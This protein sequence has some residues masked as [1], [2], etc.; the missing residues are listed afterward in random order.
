MAKKKNLYDTLRANLVSVLP[1]GVPENSLICPLCW[2]TVTF[3]ELTIEHCVPQSV[4]GRRETLTC[5]KC[6][7][8]SGRTVD[9]HLARHQRLV[10]AANGE[11]AMKSRLVFTEE[12]SMTTNLQIERDGSRTLSIVGKAS[13]PESV[14][15]LLAMAQ[16]GK[17]PKD[18]FKVTI[19]D[20]PNEVRVKFA[21]LR[22][23]YLSAFHQLGY[24]FAFSESGEFLRNIFSATVPD[25]RTLR[26]LTGVKADVRK[27]PD[28]ARSFIII[29]FEIEG[30][31]P[32]SEGG[33]STSKCLIGL[34]VFLKLTI[35][36]SSIH[37]IMI[38]AG[39]SSPREFLAL[40]QL[41]AEEKPEKMTFT[42]KAG[43]IG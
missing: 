6:N 19:F 25:S 34:L 24:A 36:T 37:A 26:L 33:P 2:Q 35:K 10:D 22:A 11:G 3:E 12:L 40:L 28:N 21:L 23:G 4:G 32:D 43:F 1:E 15:T 20:L 8:N 17:L 16:Q 30:S 39:N 41:L 7:N 18:E 38:P 13:N 9:H 29:P 5:R 42:R 31:L 27:W 14:E